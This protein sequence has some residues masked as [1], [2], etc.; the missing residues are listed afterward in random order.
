LLNLGILI[1]GRGSNMDAILAAIKSGKIKNAKPCVVMSNKPD[2]AG[3]KIAS[4]KYGVPTKVVLP[5][6]AKGWDYDQKVVAALQ[7]YGVTPQSGG[8]VC[9]AGF[10]RIISPEFVRHFKMRILN[11]HPALLPAFPGLHAQRQAID[12][13][14][15][16]SGC[17]VHF[18][19]EGVD[20][21]PVIL[22]RGVPVM[23]GDTEDSLSARILEQE[24]ELYPEAVRLFA[25]GRIKVEG[26]KVSIV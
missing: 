3:L 10:M 19:D 12:Y 2:A 8:L 26:R 23:D 24:H 25:E 20:S 1:S 17:T 21:G 9:L 6:G 16:L 7:E 22:Q 13:G 11:I 15:K 14:A 18:V 4:E 5:E